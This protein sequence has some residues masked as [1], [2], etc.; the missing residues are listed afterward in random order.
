[1]GMDKETQSRI[2]EPFFTTKPPGQGTGL[3]LSTVFGIVEQCGGSIWVYSE[4][5]NGTTFKL[6]FPLGAEA[7]TPAAGVPKQTSAANGVGTILVVDDHPQIRRLAGTILQRRG[8]TVLLA[9]GPADALALCATHAGSIDVLLSDITMPGMTGQ[10]L[11]EA[12]RAQRPDTRVLY[13]SGFAND[14]VQH[15]GFLAESVAFVSKPFTPDSLAEAVHNV[16]LN[17]G[18]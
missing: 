13:M 17:S 11:A 18:A 16:L 9:E 10:Q 12:V 8:Y 3:G 6:Y 2:F 4:P 15:H 14:A 1:M 5:G 7:V